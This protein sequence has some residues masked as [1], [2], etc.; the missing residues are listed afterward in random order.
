MQKTETMSNLCA[1]QIGVHSVIDAHCF[2]NSPYH[3]AGGSA[4]QIRWPGQ[5]H[6]YL[7]TK[8]QKQETANHGLAKG[9]CK[10]KC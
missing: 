6:M 8:G 9:L 3:W 7:D 5:I 4:P 1:S 10:A 2:C